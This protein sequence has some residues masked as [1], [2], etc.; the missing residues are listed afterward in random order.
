[1]LIQ[2]VIS[3]FRIIIRRIRNSPFIEVQQQHVIRID[4]QEVVEQ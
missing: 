1:M 4:A 3:V 2:V